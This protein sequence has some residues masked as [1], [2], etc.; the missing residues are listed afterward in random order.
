M[1]PRENK[2]NSYAKFE[3]I[4]EEYSGI[5]RNGLFFLPSKKVRNK[6]WELSSIQLE[7]IKSDNKVM[8]DYIFFHSQLV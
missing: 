8:N 2:N 1:V 4:N 7:S 5:F 3:G 6:R